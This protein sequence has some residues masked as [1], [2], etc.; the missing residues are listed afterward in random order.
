M[1]RALRSVFLREVLLDSECNMELKELPTELKLILAQILETGD[2][3][4]LM[5]VDTGFNHLLKFKPLWIRRAVQ[6]GIYQP[7]FDDLDADSIRRRIVSHMREVYRA[8]RGVCPASNARLL[9]S[10][11]IEDN[12]RDLEPII[13]PTAKESITLLL[14]LV[15]QFGRVRIMHSIF[16]YFQF[17]PRLCWLLLAVRLENYAAV[18]YFVEVLQLP[19]VTDLAYQLFPVEN[20]SWDP[21]FVMV[22][23]NGRRPN[24]T[25]RHYNDVLLCEIIRCQNPRIVRYLQSKLEELHGG[26]KIEHPNPFLYSKVRRHSVEN[27]ISPDRCDSPD[28]EEMKVNSGRGLVLK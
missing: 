25:F 4:S 5:L 24:T 13:L 8:I 2:L 21:K 14:P 22:D 7:E 9:S 17:P 28:L 19:L 12:A 3:F 20:Q 26:Q 16:T 15:V 23:K 6:Y 1:Q 10:L 18:K 11:V 27:F